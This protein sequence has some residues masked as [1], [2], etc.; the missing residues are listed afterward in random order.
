MANI[1][2]WKQIADGMGIDY[3]AYNDISL[4][5]EETWIKILGE[6]LTG[7]PLSDT[8]IPLASQTDR[9]QAE[10]DN[11]PNKELLVG[12]WFPGYDVTQ[13]GDANNQRV[14]DWSGKNNHGL[15]GNSETLN[16]SSPDGVNF[17]GIEDFIQVEYAENMA[18]SQ[19]TPITLGVLTLEDIMPN[20][21]FVIS[22]NS[23]A[24]AIHHSDNVYAYIGKYRYGV[25]SRSINTIEHYMITG[26]GSIVNIYK[27]GTLDNG[28]TTG[29]Y[30]SN[31]ASQPLYIG[32]E[33]SGSNFKGKIYCAYLYVNSNQGANVAL[34][35][36]TIN[37]ALAI[38]AE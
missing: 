29:T 18:G 7:E 6:L 2:Y 22:Q 38:L 33:A 19:Y 27:N 4:Q 12:L 24:R 34:I 8:Y 1:N 16:T 15:R 20:N 30:N 13:E 32:K 37:N 36:T 23:N 21:G 31:P 11:I 28:V 26:D 10:V 17:D 5:Y 35:N 25:T 3:S 14:K 9:I